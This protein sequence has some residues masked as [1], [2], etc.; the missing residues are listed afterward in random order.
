MTTVDA[1]AMRP[2]RPIPTIAV[3]AIVAVTLESWNPATPAMPSA[4]IAKPPLT[5][6]RAPS[7]CI[8]AVDRID[9]TPNTAANGTRSRP[10]VTTDSPWTFSSHW[11][12]T[13]S[14]PVNTT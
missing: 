2:E 9:A 3:A 8:T 10:T 12:I 4:Q 6:I 14:M 1:G 7:R 13:N 5:V 11:G